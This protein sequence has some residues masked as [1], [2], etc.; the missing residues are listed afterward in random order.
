MAP[1]V[2]G[3]DRHAKRQR[4][5]TPPLS[6]TTEQ[7]PHFHCS[8]GSELLYEGPCTSVPLSPP[9][10]VPSPLRRFSHVSDSSAPEFAHGS[11]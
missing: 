2:P 10:F 4:R 11:R 5:P 6:A 7:L 9:W 1:G 3:S 8:S